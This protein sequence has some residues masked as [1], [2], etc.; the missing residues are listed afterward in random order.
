MSEIKIG[1]GETEAA[2]LKRG[3]E[4][5]MTEGKTAS[6]RCRACGARWTIERARIEPPGETNRYWWCPNG[7]NREE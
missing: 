2:L 1:T 5:T 3:V 4:V 7:C 6:L